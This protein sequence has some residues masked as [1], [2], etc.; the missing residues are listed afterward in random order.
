MTIAEPNEVYRYEDIEIQVLEG[1]DAVRHRPGMFLGELHT[2]EG[3]TRYLQM[4]LGIMLAQAHGSG[5]DSLTLTQHPDGSL[6]LEHKGLPHEQAQMQG[7]LLTLGMA[8][9]DSLAVVNAMSA[10]LVWEARAQGRLLRQTWAQGEALGPPEQVAHTD[11]QGERLLFR[12]DPALWSP[13][14]LK[15]HKLARDLQLQAALH[16]GLRLLVRDVEAGE[17][18][19]YH[20]PRGV[21]DLMDHLLQGQATA[22]QPSL[23]L[24][25][26]SKEGDPPWR[27]E[28][29]LVLLPEHARGLQYSACG[30]QPTPEGGPHLRG[31]LRGLQAAL[32][33][34]AEG[35]G[36][37]LE[38]P[39]SLGALSRG[40][41]VV[42]LLQGGHGR[43]NHSPLHHLLLPPEEARF[44]QATQ[45]ALLPRLAD[46]PALATLL[47]QRA[48]R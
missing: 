36:V 30:G 47:L 35:L 17:E 46:D 48:L 45:R 28:L 15:L 33:Q 13:P 19:S 9:G 14:R 4:A 31:V 20:S 42:V 1:L 3:I 5:A 8:W 27:L 37:S 7:L 10:P 22:G 29:R 11:R 34:M 23:G 21:D 38:R 40:L 18:R 12:P 26:Q 6:E 41:A 32:A 24:C 43:Q 39:L 44:A 16:P 2:Q 25:V